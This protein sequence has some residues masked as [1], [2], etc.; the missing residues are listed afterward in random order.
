MGTIAD[1]VS[2]RAP[3]APR[4]DHSPVV[5]QH[6]DIKRYSDK[7][8]PPADARPAP[9]HLDP[10]ERNE[11]W[12]Q[13]TKAGWDVWASFGVALLIAG[14][15]LY[16]R[17]RFRFRAQPLVLSPEEIAQ[18][19]EGKQLF[20]KIYGLLR[21]FQPTAVE[22]DSIHYTGV[23]L[24]GDG[25]VLSATVTPRDLQ[26]FT[27]GTRNCSL[28]MSADGSIPPFG[29][30]VPDA[31]RIPFVRE[32]LEAIQGRLTTAELLP[33]DPGGLLVKISQAMEA[34]PATVEVPLKHVVDDTEF[35][36]R[37][38]REIH[39]LEEANTHIGSASELDGADL[40]RVIRRLRPRQP[41]RPMVGSYPPTADSDSILLAQ[42]FFGKEEGRYC[43]ASWAVLERGATILGTPLADLPVPDSR[44]WVR[45]LA[46][47]VGSGRFRLGTG[48]RYAGGYGTELFWSK[49]RLQ[50]AE[51]E[52]QALRLLHSEGLPVHAG[53]LRALAWGN[54]VVSLERGSA[55]TQRAVDRG[56]TLPPEQEV[57]IARLLD[58][59]GGEISPLPPLFD[60]FAAVNDW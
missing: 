30:T 18:R 29:D 43:T 1:R 59:N 38:P 3:F 21:R 14:V 9:F 20:E 2:H 34:R 60:Q 6:V 23:A 27:S 36:A 46:I 10:K 49:T 53:N 42:P 5:Q 39:A 11:I 31:D 22:H 15:C 55:L 19:A 57:R 45:L 52:L 44:S 41:I 25:S 8:L 7:Y 33:A 28:S 40:V 12:P 13:P 32:A 17:N 16:L 37:L 47:P 35:L 56:F 24:L 51:L 50:L 26:L 54:P 4:P 58:K 48:L